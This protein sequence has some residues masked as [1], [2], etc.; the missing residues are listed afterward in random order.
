MNTN[1]ELQ[2]TPVVSA[3][4]PHVREVIR[5]AEQELTDLLRQRA[6]LMKRIGAI[7]Q[8]LTGMANL[9]GDSILNEELRLL[10]EG[11]RS[12]RQRGFT[13]ACR[14]ILME[15]GAPLP[16]QRCREQLRHRF[17]ELA[18]RHKDLAASVTTVLH[19]LA[20]YGEARCSVDEDGN[21]LWAWIAEQGT[22][23]SHTFAG[24]EKTI[25]RQ[26]AHSA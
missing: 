9:F 24:F 13:E 3:A 26:P 4:L 14:Q 20:A 15:A 25:Q 19:R 7:K 8:T 16:V 6:D 5:T 23:D 22:G 11:R 12:E 1:M 21:R 18:A 10:L 2:D 17:P